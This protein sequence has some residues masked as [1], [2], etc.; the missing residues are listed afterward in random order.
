MSKTIRNIGIIAV[1]TVLTVA[2]IST[3]VW[4]RSAAASTREAVAEYGGRGICGQAGLD[5]AAQAL[6]MTADELT[7]QFRAGESL[8]DVADAEGVDVQTVLDAV[9]DAC[10]QAMRDN[11]EQAV[12]DGDL[13]RAHADWLLEGLD[14]GY[15]GPGAEG[16][17]GFGGHHG[18]MGSGFMGGGMHG[19]MGGRGGLV[20]PASTPAAGGSS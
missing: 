10:T 7:A 12:T 1:V 17:F 19:F 9:T 18:F 2:A 3:A 13:T 11:I 15:W 16:G 6:G 4:V 14:S 20:P 5:V 8:A